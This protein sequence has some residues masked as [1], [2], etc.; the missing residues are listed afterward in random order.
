MLKSITCLASNIRE[1]IHTKRFQHHN[2]HGNT[3]VLNDNHINLPL[4]SHSTIRYHG[5]TMV[6]DSTIIT[7]SSW[8][9]SIWN[10]KHDTVT[11]SRAHINLYIASHHCISA[12][13]AAVIAC[14]MRI[15][16]GPA[17]HSP[18]TR[19]ARDHRW[20]ASIIRRFKHSWC[21]ARSASDRVIHMPRACPPVRCCHAISARKD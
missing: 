15:D 18:S 1:I 21:D 20:N 10:I 11:E 4:Y 5:I 17:P 19:S 14:V 12:D 7:I 6:Y 8:T 2:S 3:A 9:D 13:V 16:S